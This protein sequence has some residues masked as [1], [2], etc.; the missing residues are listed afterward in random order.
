[1]TLN[2]YCYIKVENKRKIII[3]HHKNSYYKNCHYK[4]D[5]LYLAQITKTKRKEENASG[6]IF[7][8]SIITITLSDIVTRFQCIIFLT[9][10]WL[11]ITTFL[12]N[13]FKLVFIACVCVC[14]FV[15]ICASICTYV[16]VCVHECVYVCVCMPCMPFIGPPTQK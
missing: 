8:F 12:N 3:H 14:V 10:H 5:L 16:Y 15:C 1:V 2:F 13:T 9:I 11:N 4:F 6:K 7:N